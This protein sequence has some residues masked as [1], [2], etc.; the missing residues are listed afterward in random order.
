MHVNI[1]SWV[2]RLTS[3]PAS[4]GGPAERPAMLLAK[5]M[6]DMKRAVSPA[7]FQSAAELLLAYVRNLVAKPNEEKFRRIKVLIVSM[8]SAHAVHSYFERMLC[9]GTSSA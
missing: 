7:A 1:C 2:N 6:S 3:H 8:L 5:A 9:T 4:A